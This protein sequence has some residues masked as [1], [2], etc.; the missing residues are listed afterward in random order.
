MYR[1]HKAAWQQWQRETRTLLL[2]ILGTTLEPR[3]GSVG[4]S[5]S[6]STIYCPLFT[7]HYPPYLSIQSHRS[8][9]FS[10]KESSRPVRFPC[11]LLPPKTVQ[12]SLTP[13]DLIISRLSPV[14]YRVDPVEPLP[15]RRCHSTESAHISRLK[16]YFS[17]TWS[18]ASLRKGS[19]QEK[20]CVVSTLSQDEYVLLCGVETASLNPAH[21]LR[22]RWDALRQDGSLYSEGRNVTGILVY[23][24]NT[25]HPIHPSGIVRSTHTHRHHSRLAP[26]HLSFEPRDILK[27]KDISSQPWYE[28]IDRLSVSQY[29][30]S[31]R[32]S[33]TERR[34]YRATASTLNIKQA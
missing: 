29:M 11:V 6:L 17:Q 12:R 26:T 21:V 2:Q 7:I 13:S 15:D 19:F 14:T 20:H 25:S 5:T 8:K 33:L 30:V 28:S 10:R 24:V 27:I 3:Q 23:N 18:P 16:P 32:H 1:Y 34:S 4:A 9:S 22:R 31:W